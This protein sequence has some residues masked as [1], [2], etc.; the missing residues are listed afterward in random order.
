MNSNIKTVQV[1]VI[2][3]CAIGVLHAE[4]AC[5]GGWHDAGYACI[6]ATKAMTWNQGRAACRALGGDLA[7]PDTPEKT[8]A[9]IQIWNT[10]KWGYFVSIGM[11]RSVG[12]K[13]VW[14]NRKPVTWDFWSGSN[15]TSGGNED[16]VQMTNTRWNEWNGGQWNDFPCDFSRKCPALCQMEKGKP[17]TPTV[18]ADNATPTDGDDV[19]LTCTTPTTGITEY[20]FKKGDIMIERYAFN[21]KYIV[22]ALIGRHDGTYTCIAYVDGVA[23]D[24]S[25]AYAVILTPKTPSLSVS[26]SDANIKAGTPVTLTCTTESSGDNMSYKFLRDSTLVATESTSSHVINSP[27]SAETGAYTCV[28]TINGVASP[29]SSSHAMTVVD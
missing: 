23:S 14:I 12:N 10:Q 9:V 15:P 1:I 25:S 4:D 24:E 17:V 13:F 3:A 29:A 27:T 11:T 19:I 6:R 26:P 2:L 16:C 7:T 28:V 18:T 5:P 8:R 21:T 20:A 22:E